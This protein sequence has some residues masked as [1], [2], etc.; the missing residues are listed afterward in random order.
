MLGS[1]AIGLSVGGV[2]GIVVRLFL[3]YYLRVFTELVSIFSIL[4]IASFTFYQAGVN[5]RMNPVGAY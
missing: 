5:S 2:A 1:L 3:T 4:Q